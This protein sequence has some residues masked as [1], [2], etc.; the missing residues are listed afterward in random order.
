MLIRVS[1]NHALPKALAV[2][3]AL[4]CGGADVPEGFGL[5]LALESNR[6]W[7]P[8]GR[9]GAAMAVLPDSAQFVHDRDI[10]RVSPRT[11]TY[12][13]V[14]RSQSPHT[15]ILLTE[16]CSHY[17]IICSQRPPDVEHDWIMEEVERLMTM[18]PMSAGEI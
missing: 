8:E 7:L 9:S 16:S 4:L 18:I 5:Y 15:S 14:F 2:N 1:T 6:Q 17:C 10:I 13:V 11:G 3:T 12:R